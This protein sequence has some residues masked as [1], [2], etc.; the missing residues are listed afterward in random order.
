MV[1]RNEAELQQHFHELPAK[2]KEV[3]SSKLRKL[4]ENAK[5]LDVQIRHLYVKKEMCIALWKKER[6]LLT[7]GR[8][9]ARLAEDEQM[10]LDHQQKIRED[11]HDLEQ[12]LEEGSEGGRKNRGGDEN[13][14]DR[15]ELDTGLDTAYVFY[16]ILEEAFLKIRSGNLL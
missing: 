3:Q 10:E 11:I 4:K 1:F 16:P 15:E 2:S 6:Q 13:E 8:S 12:E 14:S 5:E 9:V 7:T